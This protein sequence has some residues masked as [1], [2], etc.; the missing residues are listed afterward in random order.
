[1][2]VHVTAGDPILIFVYC[3]ALFILGGAI[4]VRWGATWAR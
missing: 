2:K 3:L 1:M 4:G